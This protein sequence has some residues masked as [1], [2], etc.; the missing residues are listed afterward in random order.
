[1]N[2]LLSGLNPEQKEAV[3]HNYGPLLILAGAG[4]GKTTVLVAR[5]GRLIS[6]EIVEPK[7][8]CVLTFTNKAARELKERVAHKLG[9]KGK[10]IWAGTFH[11]FGLSILKKHYKK[12]GLPKGF[13]IIDSSDAKTI[14]KQQLKNTSIYD[15]ESFDSDKLLSLFSD[16]RERG[17]ITAKTEDP[18]EQVTQMILP[19]YL[20]Q[21]SFLGVVDFD[22]LLLKPLE[23]FENHPEVLKEYQ[24]N[25]QQLMVDEFQ[26]TN[27]M[28]MNLVKALSAEHKNVTVV[29][30]DDQS[31]YGWR[32][33]KVE[34]I[35]GFPQEFKPC[36]VVRLVRNY[37]SKAK[38]LQVANEVISKNKD[39]HGKEL[40]ASGY[41]D[42][43]ELPEVFVYESEDQEAEELVHQIIHFQREGYTYKDMA[44]LYRSN[45]QGGLLEGVLKQ[46][47][48]TYSL[49]G[50]SAFFERKEVKDVL[51]YL[52]CSMA[53]NELNF[54][55]IINT[56]HRGIGEGTLNKLIE[57]SNAN[58]LSLFRATRKWEQ[59]GLK[60]ALGSRLDHLFSFLDELP[61][62]ILHPP[63]GKTHGEE[64]LS[65][66]TQLGY[67]DF[68]LDSYKERTVGGKRWALIEVFTRV[69]DSFIRKGGAT[70]KTLR[71]FI[72]CM[73]LRDQLEE[74]KEEQN[75]DRVQLMTLHSC[76]GLE[77]PVVF[78][79]GVEED[80]IPHRT[81]GTDISE[82]RR[83]F[84]VGLTR[85]KERLVL[86]R[87]EQR[88]RFGKWQPSAPSRFLLEI[89][90]ELIK[91]YNGPFRPVSEVDRKSMLKDLF[92]KI[93]KQKAPEDSP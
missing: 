88:K 15:K 36:K 82:E 49:T 8:I 20:K 79:L 4:S 81:L 14:V 67:R 5:T 84:Y 64:F 35:L 75:P 23:L 41:S 61:G 38:I 22:G 80:I 6:Q 58:D 76:K 46:N 86:T 66:L 28:Q 92:A 56:P 48:V 90:P 73:E 33:A 87:A 59:A 16:W 32:G 34:N 70:V 9:T 21:L 63:P 11:S 68:V 93:D 27:I 44:L 57:Y 3:L 12:V 62:K 83:L 51:S 77:F 43:G 24:Q 31:I 50:G 55:R 1:M 26:D 40:M 18:Y 89:S 47:S 45:S 74:Q 54:R 85:A 7:N 17:Q 37:R 71:E 19:R 65:L 42:E 72:E 78:I 52:R 60:S 30:D 39:R 13:G 69:L 2:S 29:G 10:D 53:P 91:S 25:I